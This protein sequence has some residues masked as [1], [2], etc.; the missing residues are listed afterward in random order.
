MRKFVLALAMAALL[1]LP[2]L[3][4]GYGTISVESGGSSTLTIDTSVTE[5]AIDIVV[6]TDVAAYGVTYSLTADDGTGPQSGD[7]DW[8]YKVGGWTNG[9]MYP[10]YADWDPNS[11]GY[12]G[13]VVAYGGVSVEGLP[14]EAMHDPD[15][16][17]GSGMGTP[18]YVFSA[19][20]PYD[21]TASV[22]AGSYT[23]A[24]YVLLSPQIMGT[25]TIS[26]EHMAWEH[27][28]GPGGVF[29]GG[30]NDTGG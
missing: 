12:S 17:I 11:W 18:G 1:A 16:I 5:I 24:S 26:A 27:I 6:N 21:N 13:S 7:A 14:L 10:T 2:G 3:T 25:W 29:G 4:F 20:G 30:I 22:A 9:N 15:L 28:V 8:V 23:L 19:Q